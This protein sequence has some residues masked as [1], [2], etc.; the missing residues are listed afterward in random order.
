MEPAF[1]IV[2]ATLQ[3]IRLSSLNKSLIYTNLLSLIDFIARSLLIYTLIIIFTFPKSFILY[4]ITK[5]FLRLLTMD[6]LGDTSKN[7]SMYM[8]TI[9]FL[10]SFYLIRVLRSILKNKKPILL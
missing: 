10:S 4:F 9:V 2:V 5:F 8:F 1:I 3:L 7:L 6:M